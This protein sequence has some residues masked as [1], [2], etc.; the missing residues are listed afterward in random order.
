MED[1]LKHGSDERRE[2][3]IRR[4]HKWKNM[5]ENTPAF[6]SYYILW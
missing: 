6:L 5:P 3:F 2:N 1:Y 4:N